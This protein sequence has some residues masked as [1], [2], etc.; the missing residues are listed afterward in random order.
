MAIPWKTANHST[1][2]QASLGLLLL[3]LTLRLTLV[4][5]LHPRGC[6][7]MKACITKRVSD[8]DKKVFYCL[9]LFLHGCLNERSIFGIIFA[10]IISHTVASRRFRGPQIPFAPL[11]VT[12]SSLK[13]LT[14]GCLNCIHALFGNFGTE[15]VDA[16]NKW[17]STRN[18]FA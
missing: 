17:S 9:L 1:V 7:R 13:R 6:K 4:L 10:H 8:A 5:C 11:S 15:L 14:V 3:L 2:L 16:R 12:P 18:L